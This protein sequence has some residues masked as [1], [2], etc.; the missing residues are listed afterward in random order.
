MF[1]FFSAALESIS[2]L[3][4]ERLFPLSHRL[5]G[6]WWWGEEEEEVVVCHAPP[7]AVTVN[8]ICAIRPP[9]QRREDGCSCHFVI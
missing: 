9:H 8:K 3:E 1:C 5:P 2:R 6:V 4:S 7:S